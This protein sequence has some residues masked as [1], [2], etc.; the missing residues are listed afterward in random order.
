MF[1]NSK[2][3][4]LFIIQYIIPLSQNK[5]K[6]KIASLGLIR[7]DILAWIHS[8]IKCHI[9]LIYLLPT[10]IKVICFTII[11]YYLLGFQFFLYNPLAPVEDLPLKV[12]KRCLSKWNWAQM[13]G[14]SS[15]KARIWIGLQHSNCLLLSNS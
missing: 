9:H 8:Q 3:N 7:F 10:V 12:T 11:V 13:L 2:I 5:N 1:C 6:N 15:S 14:L 4:V